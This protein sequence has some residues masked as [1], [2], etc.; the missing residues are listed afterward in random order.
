MGRTKGSKNGVSTT[1]GYV[2]IGQRA[3]T[4]GNSRL[5]ELEA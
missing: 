2:A 3:K 5:Q 4:T 1:P